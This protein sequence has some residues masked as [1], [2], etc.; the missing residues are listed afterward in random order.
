[1]DGAASLPAS[2]PAVGEPP[3]EEDEPLPLPVGAPG[4]VDASAPSMGGSG[5]DSWVVPDAEPPHAATK[6]RT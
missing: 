3:L 2:S 4:K 1:V 5:A 6:P